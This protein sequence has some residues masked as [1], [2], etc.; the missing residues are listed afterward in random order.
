M[1]YKLGFGVIRRGRGSGTKDQFVREEGGESD[2]ETAE[3]AADVCYCDLPYQW[4]RCSL[5]YLGVLV[6]EG[7]IVN[8]PVHCGGGDGAR[9]GDSIC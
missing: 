2:E 5:L 3:A 6:Y 4:R 1:D 8:G 9:W 7:G